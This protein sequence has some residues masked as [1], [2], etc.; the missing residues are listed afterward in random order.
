VK[1]VGT[2]TLTVAALTSPQQKIDGN[3]TIALAANGV[4]RLQAKFNGTAWSW[5]AL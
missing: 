4:A 1:N 5:Y 3:N 2:G